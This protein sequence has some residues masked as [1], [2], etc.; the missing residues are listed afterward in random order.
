MLVD[1]NA[2]GANSLAKLLEMSGH[3]VHVAYDGPAAIEAA[4]ALLPDIVLAWHHGE[5]QRDTRLRFA[6]A[7]QLAE[8]RF[9][10]DDFLLS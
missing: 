2:D 10:C 6:P 7:K 4:T 9:P 8:K 1:D 5:E 3:E